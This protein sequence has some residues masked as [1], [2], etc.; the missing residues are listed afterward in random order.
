MKSLRSCA[1]LA[2]VIRA[3]AVGRL[4]VFTHT[5]VLA[6]FTVLLRLAEALAA[7]LDLGLGGAPVRPRLG[8][9]LLARLDR[10]V[11]LEEVLDLQALELGHVMDVPQVLHPGVGGRHAEHLVVGAFSSRIRNIP[12]TRQ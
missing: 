9:Y 5:A 6:G 7:G 10:L 3:L 11:D 12:M 4:V 2:G 8:A 1:A